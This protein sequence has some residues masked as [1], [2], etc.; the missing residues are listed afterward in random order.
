MTSTSHAVEAERLQLLKL[1]PPLSS[2]GIEAMLHQPD[3]ALTPWLHIR[4]GTVLTHVFMRDGYYCA[5]LGMR[6]AETTDHDSA[7]R[8]IAYLAGVPGVPAVGGS[9]DGRRA[10]RHLPRLVHRPGPQWVSGCPEGQRVHQRVRR[11][12]PGV[13]PYRHRPRR[14]GRPSRRTDGDR[15]AVQLT[16]RPSAY[17]RWE[18]SLTSL[19]IDAGEEVR[20][21]PRGR[22][23][24]L[25]LP[26][27]GRLR[28]LRPKRSGRRPK[29]RPRPAGEW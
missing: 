19:N 14:P 25:D 18:H 28:R 13:L 10:A 9:R 11:G 29:P 3:H 17:I 21:L 20:F 24:G 2:Y 12:T 7:V 26:P 23:A 22:A 4:Y 5:F 1:V 16:A 15:R 8:R 27:R 6:M